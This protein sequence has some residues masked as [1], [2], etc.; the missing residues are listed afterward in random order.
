MSKTA[1]AA[2][3]YRLLFLGCL[4]TTI[5]C[6]QE[7]GNNLQTEERLWSIDFFD[8]F[9]AFD[10]ANWQDQ[11]IWVNNESHAYVPDGKYNT[12]EVSD[13]SLKIRV[14]K[15]D[16]PIVSDTYDKFGNLH[17]A[18]AYVAGRICSKNRKEFVKGKW[19]ARLKLHSSGQPS[20]F[21]AWWILGAQNNESPVQEENE[22]VCWPLYGSGEIDIFEHHGDY[23]AKEFTTGAIVSLDSCDKGD[24]WSARKNIATTLT[25]YH[26]YSVEWDDAD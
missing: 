16:T 1:T 10:D 5:S 11:R 8:D 9:D 4:T 25:E 17:P 15:L 21:P 7:K 24:W 22:N 3:F 26:E 13:G 6:T 2:K 19:T 23:T 12:R 18:T 20:Q 14:V